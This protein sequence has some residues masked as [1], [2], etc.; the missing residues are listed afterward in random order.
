MFSE[1]LLVDNTQVKI[2]FCQIFENMS[3]GV[4]LM[5]LIQEVPVTCAK[6]SLYQ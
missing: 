6:Y 4:L 2:L 5:C 3:D 1:E